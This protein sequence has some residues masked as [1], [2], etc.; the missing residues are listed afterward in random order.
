MLLKGI[1]AA[2]KYRNSSD[3]QAVELQQS[4]EKEGVRSTLARYTGLAAGSVETQQIE[5]LYQQMD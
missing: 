4:I 3:P 5:A 1:A 2:L